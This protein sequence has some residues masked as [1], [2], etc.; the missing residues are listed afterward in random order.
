MGLSAQQ[1][2]RID[3]LLAGA[4]S[5]NP[6]ATIRSALPGLSVSQCDPEDL[7]GEA[8]FRRVGGYDLFLVD[9]SSHCWRIVDDPKAASGVVLTRAGRG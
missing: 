1:L 5:A 6:V 3:T 4:G 8:A 2:E 9:S 7:R